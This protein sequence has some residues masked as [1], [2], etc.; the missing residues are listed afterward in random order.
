VIR[1]R[2]QTKNWNEQFQVHSRV[3]HRTRAIRHNAREYRA[4][5]SPC[6]TLRVYS[7]C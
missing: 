1:Q 6:S 4:R 5:R 7:D 2:C 3:N